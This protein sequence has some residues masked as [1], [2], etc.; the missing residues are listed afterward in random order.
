M[1]PKLLSTSSKFLLD[2]GS[3][4]AC[5]EK[6]E[7]VTHMFLEIQTLQIDCNLG[8][9]G[10]LPIAFIFTC[11]IASLSMDNFLYPFSKYLTSSKF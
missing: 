11:H 5:V 6:N 9:I 4:N 1:G 7:W 10:L 8:H 3:V 2:A